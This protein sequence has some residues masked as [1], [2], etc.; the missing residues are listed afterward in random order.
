MHD[1]NKYSIFSVFLQCVLSTILINDRHFPK[2]QSTF[3]IALQG[4]NH[5]RVCSNFFNSLI[6]AHSYFE[7]FTRHSNEK[8]KLSSFRFT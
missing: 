2:N 6:Q 8:I 7:Y 4:V 5:I 1:S 3:F